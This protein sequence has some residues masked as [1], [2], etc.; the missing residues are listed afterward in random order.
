MHHPLRYI[1]PPLI[2]ALAVVALYIPMHRHAVAVRERPHE[3]HHK[4]VHHVT[5]AGVVAVA[6][7][8]AFIA[9]FILP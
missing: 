6:L 5:A 3:T 9:A 4:P 7:I 2:V 8:I 1:V